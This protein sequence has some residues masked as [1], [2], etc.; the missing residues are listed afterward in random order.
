M[1]RR[2]WKGPDASERSKCYYPASIV[3]VP[4]RV[5][6]PG[7]ERVIKREEV[8]V[9][10]S[11]AVRFIILCQLLHCSRDIP[12]VRVELRENEQKWQLPIEKLVDLQDC[13][14]ERVQFVIRIS[15]RLSKLVQSLG[16]RREL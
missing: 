11:L 3:E 12:G 5:V 13:L 14:V 4:L 6:V 10:H 1:K 9:D 2:K 16:C 15:K 8:I 7:D